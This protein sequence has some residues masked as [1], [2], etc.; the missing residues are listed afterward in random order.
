MES[1]FSLISKEQNNQQKRMLKKTRLVPQLTF[2]LQ[3][4]Y[5]KLQDIKSIPKIFTFPIFNGKL[6]FTKLSLNILYKNKNLFYKMFIHYN[7]PGY[8]FSILYGIGFL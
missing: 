4:Q 7:F 8:Y 2:N 3:L 1:F 6:R 5:G